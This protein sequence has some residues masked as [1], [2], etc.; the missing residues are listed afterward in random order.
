MSEP[1]LRGAEHAALHK[2]I[3]TSLAALAFVDCAAVIAT[4]AI[5]VWIALQAE[6]LV[7]FAGLVWSVPVAVALFGALKSMGV[8][9]HVALLARELEA[10]GG[11]ED[12]ASNREGSAPQ[13]VP[14]TAAGRALARSRRRIWTAA[15][16][17]L[18]FLLLTTA[19][20]G[21]GFL[22]FLSECS[23]PGWS[24]CGKGDDDDDAGQQEEERDGMKQGT[25]LMQEAN[26][27]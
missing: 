14:R 11:N 19:G 10:L 8:R 7:G 21:L 20:S 12:A 1:S 23:G 17:W 5:F 27:L 3:N 16:A 24:V 22:Q 13:P 26:R 15:A 9:R 4:A 6:N 18:V 2:E 25:R